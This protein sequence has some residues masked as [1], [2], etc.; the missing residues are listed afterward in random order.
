M[1]H[2]RDPAYR[3]VGVYRRFGAI[4]YAVHCEL[5]AFCIASKAIS[6]HRLERVFVSLGGGANDR[7]VSADRH[8]FLERH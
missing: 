7:N 4:S 2:P 6:R 5:G 3:V 1:P 8:A